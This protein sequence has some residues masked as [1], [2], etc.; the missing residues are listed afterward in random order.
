MWRRGT[1]AAVVLLALPTAAQ[2]LITNQTVLVDRLSGAADLPYD[3]AGRGFIQP[4]AIS[5][6]GCFVLF[7]ADSDPLF[8]GD[9]NGARNL[10]RY[11]RCGAPTVVQVN[12]SSSGVPAEFGTTSAG[13]S[14]SNDGNRVAFTSNSASLDPQS[15]GSDEVYVKDL[16]TGVLKLVSRS[17]GPTGAPVAR[18]GPATISGDGQHVAFIASGFVDTDNFNGVADQ[19][20]LYERNMLDDTTH[21]VSVT[22]TNTAAGSAQFNG[23]GISNDGKAVSF[24][25]NTQLTPGDTDSTGDAY[26]RQGIDANGTDSTQL[27]SFDGVTQTS[28]A[29]GS[30]GRVDLSDEGAHVAW[31]VNGRAWTAICNPTC[32]PAAQLDVPNGGSN[33]PPTASDPT[34][35]RTG[36]ISPDRVF[37]RSSSPLVPGDTNGKP[38]FYTRTYSLPTTSLLTDGTLAGGISNASATDDALLIAFQANTPEL[39]ASGGFLTQAYLRV[40]PS[41]ATTLISAPDRVNE[42]GSAAITRRSVS[43]D[44]RFVVFQ[45]EGPAFGGVID[46]SELVPQVLLRDVVAGTTTL[47]SRAPDGTPADLGAYFPSVD[48]A[49]DKVVFTSSADNLTVPDPGNHVHA[50]IRDVG[51]GVVRMLDV[52]GAGTPGDGNA[53]DVRISANGAKAAFA[54]SAT[55][56][57]DSPADSNSHIYL[58]DL[59]SGAMQ[60]VDRATGG[61]IGASDAIGVDL[62]ADGSRVAF[63]SNA[64]NL[65]IANNDVLH[66]WVR[67][68]PTSTLIWASVPEDNN[69]EHAQARDPFLSADGHKVAFTD[70][71]ALFG[72]G[73]T[74]DDTR[75][76]LRDLDAGTTTNLSTGLP[77]VSVDAP[78][79]NADA[80]KATLRTGEF[81]EIPQTHLRDV[82]SGVFGPA[83]ARDGTASAPRGGS[84][85]AALSANGAC[86][87]FT[88]ASDDVVA[89]GYGPDQTHV[90]L[91]ALNADCLSGAGAGPQ[92]GGETGDTTPPVITGFS[93]TNRRFAVGPRRTAATTRRRAKKGTTF[94][95][96]LSEDAATKIVIARK[97]AGRRKGK[98]CVK[99]TRKL[100]KAKR[101]ARYTTAATLKRS[102]TH[103]GANRIAY[104]GRIGKKRLRPGPYRATLTATDAAGNRSRARRVS[105]RVVRR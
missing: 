83:A 16:T 1:L 17:D 31:A 43:A 22:A 3:G 93:M 7:V 105:F 60:V 5:A 63:A 19:D 100:R 81:N 99:P 82:A 35:A 37:F 6:D 15:V 54:S 44:G 95:F 33:T 77:G 91:R 11:S 24:T 9:D 66:V 56:L 55:N 62:N 25:S 79:L 41:G 96:R 10:F 103:V 28:N 21:M 50:Y 49:G 98:R 65:G 48:G 75:V 38:D 86:V 4:K 27:V 64:T 68:V 61:A 58:V 12:T 23:P 71:S 14:I 29:D 90:Y 47:M 89:A 80:T 46:R 45:S 97:S 26:I 30:V 20:D 70:N 78:A 92:P 18:A 88:A 101:C 67:D 84:N 40:R 76:F 42:S 52:S 69:P 85:L 59:A 51:S 34:F 53:F 73:Q 8:A 104:T 39:P 87:A 72:Y 2:A 13:A 36:G 94:R 102:K 32:T 74:T 57:P